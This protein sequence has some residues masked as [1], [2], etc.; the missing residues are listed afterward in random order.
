MGLKKN[1]NEY[2][3][4]YFIKDSLKGL[5]GLLIFY[6]ILIMLCGVW[7]EITN[8]YTKISSYLINA[9]EIVFLMLLIGCCMLAIWFVGKFVFKLISKIIYLFDLIVRA[10]EKYV[11]R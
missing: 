6:V 1:N 7:E 10:L 8:F 11:A 4:S 5:L 2:G 9:L 3:L